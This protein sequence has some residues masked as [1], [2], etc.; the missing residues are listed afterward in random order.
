MVGVRADGR[1]VKRPKGDTA[2]DAFWEERC[3]KRRFVKIQDT[4]MDTK[5]DDTYDT[6][7]GVVSC[8]KLTSHVESAENRI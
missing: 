8:R 4:R 7:S 5:T 3:E 1:T 6:T 2:E